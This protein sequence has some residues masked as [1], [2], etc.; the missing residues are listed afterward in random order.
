MSFLRQKFNV[1]RDMQSMNVRR[2]KW[3]KACLS[4]LLNPCNFKR[5]FLLPILTIKMLGLLH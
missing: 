1:K 3:K 2:E 5:I 4:F